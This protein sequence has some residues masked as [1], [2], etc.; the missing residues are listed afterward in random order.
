LKRDEG[1]ASSGRI[2]HERNDVTVMEI[3]NANLSSFRPT[4]ETSQD[5]SPLAQSIFRVTRRLKVMKEKLD[6]IV[7]QVLSRF[8]LEPNGSHVI[9]PYLDL[10][11]LPV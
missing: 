5:R 3:K 8:T 7:E 1:L 2:R 9:S 10:A 4:G 6:V 11:C